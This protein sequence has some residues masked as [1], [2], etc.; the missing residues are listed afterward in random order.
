[1]LKILC[2]TNHDL[3]G[4]DYGAALRGRKLFG[5][6]A[7]LGQ[8]KV[9]LAGSHKF[10]DDQPR[11]TFGGFQLLQK[12]QFVSTGKPSLA[13]RFRREFDPGFLNTNWHQATPA[14]RQWLQETMAQQD[15]IWVHG[16]SVADGFGIQHWPQTVLD[17]DDIP[18]SYYRSLLSQARDPLA[19][20]H[21]QRQIWIRRR[22]ETRLP[23]RFAAVCVCSQPDLGLLTKADN[24]FVLPNGFDAPSGE[25]RY[26]PVVPP[27]LG[28]IGTFG[29]EPNVEGV[30]GFLDAVWPLI[31]KRVPSARLRLSGAHGEKQN[32]QDYRNVDVLGWV[33]DAAA[34]MATW[35][36]SIVP[37]FVGGGTRIKIAET[38]SRKCPLVSTSLGAY[39]YEVTHDR[40][41]LL[42]DTPEAF[43]DCCVSILTNP[44]KGKVLAENAWKK[45]NEYWTWDK[46]ASRVAEIVARATQENRKLS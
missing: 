7:R 33:Q 25:P 24:N 40:E 13:D 18:S 11:R 6:L 10:W 19:R 8:V 17:I 9:V 41:L 39:G 12:I 45:F 16:I 27:R 28:F 20:L 42:A 36:L 37:I 44:A 43:T 32:W 30:R 22:H 23:E 14:H 2:L 29:Y 38:F 4:P 3:D 15:L 31:L 26:R 46:Q 21:W 5:L 34:E 35:S 1:M